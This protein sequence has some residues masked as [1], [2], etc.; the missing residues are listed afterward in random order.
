MENTIIDFEKVIEDKAVSKDDVVVIN[1]EWFLRSDD[2]RV[3]FFNI[4]P[5]IAG[6]TT[7]SKIHPAS[8]IILTHFDGTRTFGEIIQEVAGLFEMSTEKAEEKIYNTLDIAP[9][10]FKIV[11]NE[12]EI[13]QFDA[14]EYIMKGNA[15]D[16]ETVR[17]NRPSGMVLHIA[18]SCV[19]DCIYCNVEKRET[20]K[21]EAMTTEQIF[22]LIEEAAEIGIKTISVAGGDPFVRDDIPQI[23]KKI[24][25]HDIAFFLSTKAFVSKQT[26]R[27]LKEA[28]VHFMQVSIDAPTPKLND[29]LV[30]SKNAYTEAIDS[31]KNLIE[32]GIRLRTNSIITPHNIN[33]LPELIEQLVGLGVESIGIGAYAASMHNSD[34][35]RESLLLSLKETKQMDEI[36][37]NAREKYPDKTISGGAQRDYNYMTT[38]QREN[39]YED[40][41]YCSAGRSHFIIHEDGAMTL[42]EECFMI[43]ELIIG[44]YKESS[45]KEL[46]NSPKIL[47]II[48]PPRDKYKDTVCFDCDE[49]DDCHQNKGRCWRESYKA[50]GELWTPAPGCP[51][52][53]LGKRIY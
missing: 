52:S 13:R 29:F 6:I 47:D 40:R 50:Y 26:A 28:G 11:E 21:E 23:I 34:A 15:I 41:S 14:S 17:L 43:D 35:L 53:P 16:L 48:H 49:Y 7:T 8:A 20:P 4:D 51:K 19:R 31:I 45:L 30:N 37:K 2:T 3:L 46:W 22:K 25:A 1:S 9:S 12:N 33:E 38:K 42:C 44:N 24:K 10:A 5:D 32:Q 27:E 39:W 36:V 18:D